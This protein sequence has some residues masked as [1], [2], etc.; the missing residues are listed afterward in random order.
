M[1]INKWKLVFSLKTWKYTYVN[2]ECMKIVIILN[3]KNCTS[4]SCEKNQYW[5]NYL[6][7]HKTAH[8]IPSFFLGN[9]CLILV[10]TF[11]SYNSNFCNYKEKKIKMMKSC[12]NFIMS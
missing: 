5:N 7:I 8:K 2:I 10:K 6:K 1:Y 4:I 11:F 12:R 3:D 9:I